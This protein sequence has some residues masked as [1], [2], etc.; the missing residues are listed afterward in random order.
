MQPGAVKRALAVLGCAA[1]T[2]AFAAC[3]STEQESAR[4]ERESRA[5]VAAEQARER[6]AGRRAH[7]HAHTGLPSGSGGVGG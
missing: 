2:V 1:A 4:I 6:A 7:G 3:Q 5:A